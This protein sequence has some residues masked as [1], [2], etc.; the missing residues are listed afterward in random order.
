MLTRSSGRRGLVLALLAGLVTGVAA[1]TGAASAPPVRTT[2]ERVWTAADIHPVSAVRA[3]GGVAVVYGTAGDQ[4]MI[5]GLD[6]VTGVQLWSEPA[7]LPTD[8]SDAVA[9]HDFDGEVAYLR[10]TGSARVSQLVLAAPT[11]GADRTVSAPRYWYAFP[12]RCTDDAWIC[13]TS[14][15]QQAGGHWDL[16]RFRVNRA[17][18]DT[19]PIEAADKPVDNTYQLPVGNLYYADAADGTMEI[20]RR[21]KGVVTGRRTPPTSG[22]RRCRG[23]PTSPCPTPPAADS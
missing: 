20:G 22:V 19:V 6:P 15:V 16:R 18:G 5:Y 13:P 2:V 3:V 4:L 10:P 14:Y 9:V 11:T 1:C 17:T 8:E 7:V 21:V 23:R 12:G